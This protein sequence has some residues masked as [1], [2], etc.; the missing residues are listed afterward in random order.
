MWSNWF[1]KCIAVE[2]HRAI[3]SE[4]FSTSNMQCKH[5][6]FA[7]FQTIFLRKKW[8]FYSD[9]VFNLFIPIKKSEYFYDVLLQRQW[10]F[11]LQQFILLFPLQRKWKVCFYQCL[12]SFDK[13]KQKFFLQ[14]CKSSFALHRK[15]PLTHCLLMPRLSPHSPHLS[16]RVRRRAL[17]RQNI[18]LVAYF[19]TAKGHLQRWEMH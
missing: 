8:K 7:L 17:S 3:F 16:R 5:M 4:R 2:I 14:Q 1:G 18:W 19:F 10:K 6:I 12:W 15:C 11:Y 9:H 13:R